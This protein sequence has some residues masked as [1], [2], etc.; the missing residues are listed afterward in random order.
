MK[1]NTVNLET[2]YMGL[3]LA[4]PFV[5]SSSGLT[6]DSSKIKRLA[7][8]GVGAVVL[9]S[10]F[11]EQI[12]AE[13]NAEAGIADY[14]EAADYVANYVK[15]N[16]INDYL[17]LISQSKEK[18]DIPIIASISCCSEGEWVSFAK[19]IEQAGADALELNMFILNAGQYVDVGAYEAVYL[20]ILKKVKQVVTIPVSLKIGRNFSDLVGLSKRLV[21]QGLDGLVLFNRFYQPDIDLNT[22]EFVSGEVFSAPNDLGEVWRWLSLVKAGNKHLDVAVST[23]VHDWEGVVKSLLVGAQVVQICTTV[24]KNGNAV[25]AEMLTCLE[26]WMRQKGYASVD[27]LRGLCGATNPQYI[28]LYERVQFMKYFSSRAE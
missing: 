10:L 2:N 27:D 21:L 9:K 13:I 16:R 4:N 11:E 3:K 6:N 8:A 12:I 23:G 28:N 22:L 19:D 14:P 17:K 7:K 26:E 18:C 25:I 24:Y 1:Q 20:D 15:S 5:V